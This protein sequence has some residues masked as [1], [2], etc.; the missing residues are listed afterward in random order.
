LDEQEGAPLAALAFSPSGTTP[1]ADSAG[2]SLLVY[3]PDPLGVVLGEG[4]A[5]P[6]MDFVRCCIVFKFIREFILIC[7]GDMC[8]I[9]T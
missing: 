2:D 1:A 3:P 6:S 4:E 9:F 7:F 8:P 5:D